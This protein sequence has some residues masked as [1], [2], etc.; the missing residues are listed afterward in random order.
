MADA[1]TLMR[2]LGLQITRKG[3]N[4]KYPS[5][6]PGPASGYR[7]WAY[8]Y[9]GRYRFGVQPNPKAEIDGR[10]LAAFK[11]AGFEVMPQKTEAF[12]TLSSPLGDAVDEARVVMAKI[13]TI[14]SDLA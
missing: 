10:I 9:D 11:K 6:E 2:A 14:F 3:P 1:P 4:G 13:E 7:Y 5:A 8:V 12:M